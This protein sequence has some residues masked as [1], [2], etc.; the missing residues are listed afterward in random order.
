M[1]MNGEK[2][3]MNKREVKKMT[4]FD[5]EWNTYPDAIEKQKKVM[6]VHFRPDKKPKD[7]IEWLEL[8]GN[9][10]HTLAEIKRAEAKI[11]R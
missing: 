2:K 9:Y 10:A 8:L 4:G 7:E 6:T 11:K 1:K 5:I 3:S